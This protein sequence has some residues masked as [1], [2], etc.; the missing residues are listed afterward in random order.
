MNLDIVVFSYDGVMI[1]GKNIKLK[2]SRNEIN[3]LLGK[4][5]QVFN[6]LKGI[7]DDEEEIAEVYPFMHVLYDNDGY[8][9]A[10]E[11]FPPG[12][13]IFQGNVFLGKKYKEA[14]DLLRKMGDTSFVVD[15]SGL[16]SYRY[17]IGLYTSSVEEN[18][19]VESMI[20]FKK[21]YYDKGNELAK[22]IQEKYSSKK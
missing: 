9:E 3:H 6:R 17:G 7:L 19:E 13:P 10:F 12:N 5:I 18:L 21:G 1:D 16:T 4:P 14:E 2:M 15:E 20:V 22:K 11:I 8:C